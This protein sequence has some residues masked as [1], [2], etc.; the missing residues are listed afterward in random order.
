[1][2][3]SGETVCMY[4][5]FDYAAL[6]GL[7]MFS[8]EILS[9]GRGRGLACYRLFL[10]SLAISSPAKGCKSSRRIIGSQILISSY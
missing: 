4:F 10:E 2:K 7:H 5:F 1:M 6:P 8:W 9:R 3:S